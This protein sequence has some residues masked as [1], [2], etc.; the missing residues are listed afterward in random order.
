MTGP[1]RRSVSIVSGRPWAVRVAISAALFE[2]LL[3]VNFLAVEV[4]RRDGAGDAAIP[5]R[6]QCGDQHQGRLAARGSL[7]CPA[8]RLQR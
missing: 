6:Q 2:D 4:A 3:G 5:R 1:R 8:D 7:R